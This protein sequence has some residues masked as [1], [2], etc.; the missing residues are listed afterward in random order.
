LTK[1]KGRVFGLNLSGI[2]WVVIA[3]L[4]GLVP[5]FLFLPVLGLV[6]AATVMFGPAFVVAVFQYFFLQDKPPRWFS[7]WVETRLT[8]GHFSSLGRLTIRAPVEAYCAGGVVC[9]PSPGGKLHLSRGVRVSA[10]ENRTAANCVRNQLSACLSQAMGILPDDGRV[11]IRW[12]VSNDPGEQVKAYAEDTPGDAPEAVQRYRNQKAIHF[13]KAAQAGQL[14]REEVTL[15]MGQEVERPKPSKEEKKDLDLFYNRILRDM[16]SETGKLLNGLEAALAPAGVTFEPLDANAVAQEWHRTFNPS[17]ASRRRTVSVPSEA[18]FPLTE[19]CCPGELR[20]VGD[21]GFVLDGEYYKVFAL[22][23]LCHVAYPGI[24]DHLTTLPIPDFNITVLLHRLPRKKL[25]DELETRLKRVQQQLL[26]EQNPQLEVTRAQLEEK[27]A[28]LARGAVTPLEMKFIIVLHAA[29]PEE[30]R[31]H[32]DLLKGAAARINLQLFEANLAAS[33]RDLFLLTLPGRLHGAE[34][35]F[36]H[37]G[38]SDYLA[39]LLPLPNSFHG[40]RQKAQALFVGVY[41]N[42]IGVRTFVGEGKASTPQHCLTSGMNGSGKSYFLTRLEI[43]THCLFHK[44]YIIDYGGSHRPYSE[45]VGGKM[46]VITPDCPWTF[47]LFREPGLPD[48]SAQR[49]LTTAI[50]GRMVGAVGN[51][52][53]SQD[54]RALLA[55]HVAAVCAAFADAWL[56]RQTEAE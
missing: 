15:F 56:R 17:T 7:Q 24:P 16:A 30:L 21:R 20:G 36:A 32:E 26:R 47:N 1:P 8:G 14:R 22:R 29:T 2:K 54:K 34:A 44:S 46:L 43:E 28:Q 53:E 11:Q 6:A 3:L 40:F 31:R 23:R 39:P 49:A 27:I 5:G 19:V 48:G 38:E 25:M 41:L 42:L 50:A 33:A 35:C 13:L 45:A 12:S 9:I 10:P 4:L 37:Y 18:A 51:D 55:K 52:D